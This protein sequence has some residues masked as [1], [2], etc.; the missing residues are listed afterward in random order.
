M[1]IYI[2]G[3]ACASLAY[4]YNASVIGTTIGQPS[5]LAY[6][7][8]EVAEPKLL[9]VI[10][11]L[12]YAGGFVGAIISAPL[13][14][15]FGR[16]WAALVGAVS[17]LVV[18]AILAGSVNPGM[19][20]AFRFLV[21]LASTILFTVIPVW[22]SE[23]VPAEGRGMFV[24]AHPILITFGYCTSAF[25][26]IGFYYV[27]GD[28]NQWRG[29]LAI[30]C[31]PCILFLLAFPF[32][33][34]SPRWLLMQEQEEKARSIIQDLHSRPGDTEHAAANLEFEQVRRQI[35]IDRLLHVNYLGML[36]RPSYRKRV[37]IASALIFF[38]EASGALVINNYGTVLFGE[39]GFD[40][41]QRLLFEGGY[42]GIGWLVNFAAI[43]IVDK[44][45]RPTLMS[46]GFAGCLA[47][48]T[49]EAALQA[50]FLN[51]D[52]QPALRAS[53]AILYLFIAFYGLFLDGSTFF[54]IGEIFP[55]HLR[56][57]GMTI[58]MALLNLL[59]IVW[60]TASIYAFTNIGWKFYLPF[61]ISTA[62]ATVVIPL[63]FPDTRNK[64]LEEIGALFGDEDIL[65]TESPLENGETGAMEQ[66]KSSVALAETSETGS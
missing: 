40:V 41:E 51:S 50:K 65:V 9:S 59:S 21:G 48:L 3:M 62:I 17:T 14:D 33:P 12:F 42:V 6:M 16:R 44:L 26:G 32:L 60:Q 34:E 56:A 11:G 2:V 30:G 15:R 8:S 53:V 29:P 57:Q 54:Y 61:I 18:N 27:Q 19:F 24:D 52:N 31:L 47:T 45:P 64:P 22:I 66:L 46:L 5:F 63:T 39:L 35:E 10:V 4:G 49:I 28:G 55:N 37:I 25:V 1:I 23:I 43:F 36:T 13:S 20:I 38:L 7:G 58:A